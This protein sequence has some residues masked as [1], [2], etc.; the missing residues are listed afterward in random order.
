MKSGAK[1]GKLNTPNIPWAVGDFG[2]GDRKQEATD[3]ERLKI[4]KMVEEGKISVDEA[5]NLFKALEGE[6]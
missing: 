6:L 3:Q 5:E 2:V 1:T 4:L